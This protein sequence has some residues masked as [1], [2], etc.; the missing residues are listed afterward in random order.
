ML[1]TVFLLEPDV[2]LA[3][4]YA[5]ELSKFCDVHTFYTAE[6]AIK[7][8]EVGVPDIVV[9]ELALPSHGG[10]EFL[11]EMI[12][13]SDTAE[14]KVVINSSVQPEAIPWGYINGGDLQIIKHLY[15]P[16]STPTE[17]L[18]TVEEALR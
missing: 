8:F 6:T 14:V 1:K 16:K 4:A 18:D 2:V 17:L 3:K 13:Y 10:F 12:S 15:K 5:Y 9:L 11:Y 7:A